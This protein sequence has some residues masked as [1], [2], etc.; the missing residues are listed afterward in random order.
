[1]LH[2]LNLLYSLDSRHVNAALSRD[3]QKS[4][5]QRYVFKIESSVM[6]CLKNLKPKRGYKTTNVQVYPIFVLPQQH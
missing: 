6:A 3:P 2:A 1:M 4:F 5:V